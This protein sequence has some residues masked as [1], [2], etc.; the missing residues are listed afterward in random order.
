MT[1]LQNS[2]T[3][4]PFTDE[5]LDNFRL[6][7][8][9]LADN[10]VNIFAQQYHSSIPLLT[11]KL[12]AMIRLPNDDE[13]ITH[14][15]KTFSDNRAVCA[16][17]ENYFAI[18]DK[19]PAWAD[20]VKLTLGGHVF[21]DH[22]F[23]S[24]TALA[25]SSLPVCYICRP[26]VKALSF[27][28]RLIDKA[29]VRIAETAQMVTDVMGNGGINI[30]EHHLSGK[31]IQSILKI[32]LIHAS[33]RYLLLNKEQLVS[34]NQCHDSHNGS[35]LLPY[36]LE[37]EQDKCCWY[38][39]KKP[40][41]WDKQH[42]GVPINQ[43]VL[44]LTLLTFSYI[45]LRAY[46]TIGIKLNIE[47]ENAYLHSWNV[48]GYALGID[49][50]FLKEFDSYEKADTIYQQLILR[51]RGYTK[52][53][54]LLQQALLDVYAATGDL[55]MPIKGIF[56]FR[57]LAKLTTSIFL[58]KKSFAATGLKLHTHDYIF[59][60]MLYLFLRFFA[61]L[62]NFGM[63]RFIADA[64]FKHIARSLWGWRSELI[65][66]EKQTSGTCK[67]LIIPEHLIATSFKAGKYK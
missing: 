17:L 43:E 30:E 22:F 16:A 3:L 32:R 36:V 56:P 38:G 11:E 2:K 46:R 66:N 37:S 53:A 44:A 42:D 29:P 27:T 52:D 19:A 59:R 39:D 9:P 13:L 18:A 6:Q 47:Q 62:V 65:N 12:E 34:A 50:S 5:M 33:I 41:P 60:F 25:C 58:S 10:V 15:K 20:E 24:T 26:D 28:R 54:E 63:T 35:F 61:L 14:V 8:D 64:V 7:G 55:I 51:R 48:A 57:Y 1:S 21:Q 67:P 23:T 40:D 4:S 45:I 49:E 31:G